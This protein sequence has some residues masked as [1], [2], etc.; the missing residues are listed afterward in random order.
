MALLLCLGS[1][2]YVEDGGTEEEVRLEVFGAIKP[3][4]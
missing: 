4:S 2:M 1:G 3:D